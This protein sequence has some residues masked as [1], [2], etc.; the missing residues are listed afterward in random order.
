MLHVERRGDG[1]PVALVHGF[2]QTGR[3]WRALAAHLDGHEL[4]FVDAPGHGG[5]TDV[6]A[7]LV[8]TA[9]L[10]GAICGRADYV[11]YS[12]GGRIA[13]HLALEQ[14]EVVERLAETIVRDGV[15]AFLDT[16]LAQPMFATVPDD[17]DDRADRRRNTAE[18]LASSLRL[19]GTGTQEPLW[20]RLDRISC[21]TLV[22]AGE[23]DPKFTSLGRRLATSIPD[24]T[25][26]AVPH[27]AHAVHLE[28]P[29]LVGPLLAS[30]LGGA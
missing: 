14:P 27:A 12:M 17:A 3:S 5:S 29:D 6:H 21:P 25:F 2:T 18:G 19:A 15:D 13:L 4:L 24:S 8:G 28:R 9:T 7:D 26:V 10:V 22:V 11:G 1:P 16:W 30:F 23:L 20:A